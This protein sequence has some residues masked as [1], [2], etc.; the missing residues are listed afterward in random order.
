MRSLMIM[1]TRDNVAVALRSVHSGEMISLEGHSFQAAEDVTQG[2]KIALGD[3]QAGD[4]IIKYGY[5][6]GHATMD[7]RKGEWVHTHN[8]KTNLAGEEQYE[9]VQDLHPVVH[10]DRQLSF[11]GYRRRNGKAGIRNDLFVIPTVGCVNGIA[12][13]M[14]SEFRAI[15]PDLGGFDNLTV[16]KHPYGCSQLGEDHAMTRSILLDAVHHP[17]AG[18]VL[19]F[20]LG[21]ENN[22]VS[23]FRSMLGEYDQERVKFLVAQEVR[24]EVEAGL[25][26][27]EELYHAARNDVRVP[28]PLSELNVGLKCGGSDGFSGITANPLL[29]AFSDFLI[30]QGGTTVLT[31]VPEM[32]GAE[33]ML[34]ARAASREVYEQIVSLINNFKQYF[35]SYGEPVYENPSPGNKAGGISTLED[36]S[37]GCTQ[38]AGTAPVV[39][40]LQ[41][42]EKLRRKGLSLLQAPGNDLVAS[43]ALAAADCQ[44]VLFTTGRGTP[45]GSFVP[46]VKVATN[47]DL[48]AK[49]GHWMDFNAG[50]LLD[51]PM[52]EVLEHFISYIVEVASGRPTR[53]EQNEVRELAI[54][55]TGVTL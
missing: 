43:S 34:M 20:G 4:L 52:E 17:N 48:F 23:E 45:F 35:L 1:N 40:V 22:I 6:I 44:L 41:Y 7:I 13:Q 32:F 47:N 30:S 31:E 55:K 50:S 3:L 16:L 15:H 38:K 46:T 33:K 27:L 51:T 49:K 19:V 18:G 53:N 36:K 2:H 28:I 11:Q 39:D 37:L 25:E 9:Y 21:C 14:L 5:P 10:A 26:L 24:D 29:G 54:F 12:E 8:I 42:G